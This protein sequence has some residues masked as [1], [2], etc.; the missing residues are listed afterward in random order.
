[1]YGMYELNCI[2][3]S[4]SNFLA[5][6]PQLIYNEYQYAP[7]LYRECK[8]AAAVLQKY[9]CDVNVRLEFYMTAVLQQCG[10]IGVT[11]SPITLN[12]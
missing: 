8:A 10:L 9:V 3:G 12:Q 1:M 2:T 4:E 6:L 11:L 7:Y 5:S